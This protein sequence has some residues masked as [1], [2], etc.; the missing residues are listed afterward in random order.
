[1]GWGSK[2][3][4]FRRH[5]LHRMHRTAC[6][7]DM[8]GGG[9]RGGGGFGGGGARGGGVSR[10]GVAGGAGI[11]AFGNA[12]TYTARASLTG[13]NFWFWMPLML[14]AAYLVHTMLRRCAFRVTSTLSLSICWY[15]TRGSV[16]PEHPRDYLLTPHM[17]INAMKP[18]GT[19][20][21]NFENSQSIHRQPLRVYS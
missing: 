18:C 10:R 2:V 16:Q 3:A 12:A 7:T 11:L 4:M 14:S 13:V 8:P 20:T 5:R 1:M 17:W 15:S 6:H 21:A 19:S 9:G